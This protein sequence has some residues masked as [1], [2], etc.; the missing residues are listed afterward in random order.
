MHLET[1]LPTPEG[2]QIPSQTQSPALTPSITSSS[3][4]PT[5]SIETENPAILQQVI[6]GTVLISIVTILGLTAI[7]VKKKNSAKH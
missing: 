2:S 4:K 7:I 5:P 6:Y 1:N 3:A